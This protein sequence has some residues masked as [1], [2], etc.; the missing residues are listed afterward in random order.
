MA[1]VKRYKRGEIIFSEGDACPGLFIVGHGV[2]RI[3]RNAP[4]GKQHV[5]H[6]AYEGM[7]FA[8]VAAIGR[9]DCP[10][11]A[12]AIQDTVCVLLPLASFLREIEQDHSLCLELLVSMSVW[13]RHLV[14]MLEDIVLRDATSRVARHLLRAAV[15][16][17]EQGSSLP[18][19]KRD[20]ASHLNL[21]SE[22]LSR[23]LRRLSDAGLILT[24]DPHQIH[25]LDRKALEGV[26][27]GLPPA[28]FT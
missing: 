6:L 18:M 17:V 4:T 15:D 9:F 19:L 14:G 28:E 20:L 3:Y 1:R 25:V 22:T 27:D 26:A 21:T 12:E 13:V 24:P 11:H 23:T 10:A 5:L 7:T 8:E 16:D 2:V